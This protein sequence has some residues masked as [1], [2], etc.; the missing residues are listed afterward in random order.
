MPKRRKF[1]ESMSE[2]AKKKHA[3]SSAV[4]VSLDTNMRTC[5]DPVTPVAASSSGEKIF[6][7]FPITC[8]SV[9]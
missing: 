4:R 6:L 3:S 1:S 5:I 8:F 7:L 2:L 9:L